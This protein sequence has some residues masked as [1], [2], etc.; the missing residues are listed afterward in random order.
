MTR[1]TIGIMLILLCCLAG[2]SQEIRLEKRSNPG[3]TRTI[4]LD[5]P[6]TIR[7]FDGEKQKGLASILPDGRMTLEGKDYP[8]N[9]IMSLSGFVVRNSGDKAAGL[10]LTI[11]AGAILP[12]ALYYVLGGIAWAMP[13]GIFIGATVLT[14]DLL[15]A[16][17]GTNLMGILPR[18]FSTMNWKIDLFPRE[19]E[20]GIPLPLPFPV[21]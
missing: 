18:S 3:E 2:F 14:F 7:T 16:Y 8:V 17:I 1:I 11:G 4:R 19:G 13:N 9:S 21:E 10:G 5:K 20:P 12:L 6:L 15:L